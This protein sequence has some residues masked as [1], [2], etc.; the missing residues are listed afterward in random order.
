MKIG[1]LYSIIRVEEKLLIK[2]AEKIGLEMEK[3]DDREC[4]FGLSNDIWKYD[5]VLERCISHSKAL[6]ALK[7][8]NEYGVKTVNTY[9]VANCCGDKAFTSIAFQKHGIPTPKTFVA[10]EPES[11][12]RAIERVGYPAVMK[13]VVGS[14]GRLLAKVDSRHAAEAIIEHKEV[15]GS[16]LHQIYYVQEFVDKPQRDIR[17]FVVGDECICAV[18][19][20]SAHWI[21][22]TARGAKTT[23]CKVTDELNDLCVRAA[24]A[25]GGGIIAVDVMETKEGKYTVH[26]ANYTMEFRNSIVP[27]GVDIPAKILDYVV[28]VA[29]R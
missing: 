10:F 7:F 22:N 29:K 11:A 6:Y 14:W 23:E 5:V 15:L 9:E 27:T 25:V 28:G 26:E 13:P 12:I 8:L 1:M 2:A 19:R 20:E 16:Y 4:I 21:T 3:I 17:A 24:H 18:F